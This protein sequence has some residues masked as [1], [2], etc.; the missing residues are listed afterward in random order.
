MVDVLAFVVREVR[1]RTDTAFMEERFRIDVINWCSENGGRVT[2]RARIDGDFKETICVDLLKRR[3][4]ASGATALRMLGGC[5]A[6]NVQSWESDSVACRVNAAKRSFEGAVYLSVC[7][8][9]ARLG[10]PAEENVA[11]LAHCLPQDV[12]TYCPFAV[13]FPT[14][15]FW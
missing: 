12:A 14:L 11:V 5:S 6:S 10:D 15:A 8:D 4:V 1:D 3:R 13:P 9:G 7:S 2:K